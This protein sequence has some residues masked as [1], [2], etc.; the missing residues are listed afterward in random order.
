MALLALVRSPRARLLGLLQA[1]VGQGEELLGVS[2]Q[3][4]PG[5]L[6]ESPDQALTVGLGLP[7]AFFSAPAGLVDLGAQAGGVG[8]G[9]GQRQAGL[10]EL[11][12]QPGG[13][14]LGLGRRVA[15]AWASAIRRAWRSAWANRPT[16]TPAAAP[17]TNPITSPSIIG[18]L[19]G[20][21][22]YPPGAIAG[23]GAR[24]P[25]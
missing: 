20:P 23:D 19:P 6:G 5:H 25:Q 11:L 13:A 2:L 18:S 9:G 21:D 4:L 15:N 3:G 22:P 14:V 12:G 7:G 16:A 1:G 17:T 8:P 24:W 10:F